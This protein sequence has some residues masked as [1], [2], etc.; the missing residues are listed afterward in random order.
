MTYRPSMDGTLLRCAREMSLRST[1]SRKRV[2][3]VL[4]VDG[5]IVS[6]GY[7]G[8]PAGQRHCQHNP[9]ETFPC[10][11]ARHAEWNAL[12]FAAEHRIPVAGATLYS[13]LMPCAECASRVIGMG[14]V[15]V[16]AAELRVKSTGADLLRSSGVKV[17]RCP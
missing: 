8:A 13:T 3:A 2:G 14:I 9:G 6:S 12:L 11:D 15:R 1:C 10:P 16:V 7:N 17:A 5:R 4:A